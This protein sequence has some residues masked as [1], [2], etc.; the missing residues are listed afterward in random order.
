MDCFTTD[1]LTLNNQASELS[2]G[3]ARQNYLLND[4]SENN[5]GTIDFES[6]V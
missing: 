5:E 6:T 1:M 4:E 2:E 3:V